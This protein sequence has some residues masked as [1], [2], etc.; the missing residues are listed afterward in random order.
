M[1]RATGLERRLVR[2]L[3]TDLKRKTGNLRPCFGTGRSRLRTNK[4]FSKE[5]AELYVRVSP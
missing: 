2:E 5:K 3:P 1:V 4:G